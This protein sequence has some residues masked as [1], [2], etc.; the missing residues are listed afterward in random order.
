[1]QIEIVTLMIKKDFLHH[2]LL[3]LI[4]R[5]KT[6]FVATNKPVNITLQ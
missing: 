6:A 2:A 5:H 3:F 1:M 4:M